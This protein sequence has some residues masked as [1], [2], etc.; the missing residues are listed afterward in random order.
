[1]DADIKP[2]EGILSLSLPLIRN[3]RLTTQQ[4]GMLLPPLCSQEDYVRLA[5]G[6]GLKIFAKPFDISSKVSKTWYVSPR[7]ERCI[8][9]GQC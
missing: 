5:T 2:I 7:S 1:M 3:P 4:D 8:V 9:W 6:A